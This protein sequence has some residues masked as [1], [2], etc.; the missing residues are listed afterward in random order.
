MKLL[1]LLLL[2]PSLSPW[3][4]PLSYDGKGYWTIRL[5]VLVRNTGDRPLRGSPVRLEIRKGDETSVLIGQPV[6]SIRVVTEEGVELLFDLIDPE[7][8]P[9]REGAVAEGD[10]I[11]FPA[12]VGAGSEARVY[13]YA[14]NDKAWL[15]PEWIRASIANPSFERG[16][17]LPEG[18]EVWGTDAGHRMFRQ[19]GGAHTGEWCARC[20]VDEGAEPSWVKYFQRGMLVAEG[21]RYRFTGWVKARNVK[22]KAGWYVHVDGDK[23]MI[24]NKV[25]GWEGSFDWRKV[26]IEFTVPP[27]GRRFSC[28]TVLY[29]T[30][31]A[32]FDDAK[33]EVLDAAGTE[34]KPLRP[35]TKKLKRVGADATWEDG[36]R[37]RAP[38]IVRNF[39]DEGRESLVVIDARRIGNAAYKLI[40]PDNRAAIK[41]VDPS[42]PDPLR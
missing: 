13:I 25:V 6:R 42:S 40:G 8:E 11:V 3:H 24:I 27:T 32:W 20:E 29:G 17:D 31:T 30:G 4:H 33:L 10:A 16:D 18:W 35:E 2:L 21:V 1:F 22:G 23:P 39:E 15:P 28:G 14:G 5:P 41:I 37:W 12:E 36:W 38:V 7:G 34:A 26:T 9:K 19:R